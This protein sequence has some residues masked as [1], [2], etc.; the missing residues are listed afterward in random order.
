MAS[1]GRWTSWRPLLADAPA[2]EGTAGGEGGHP[3]ARRAHAAMLLYSAMIAT[4]FPVGAAI[5]GDLDP[6]VLTLLRFIIAALALGLFLR[7]RGELAL[8]RGGAL[9]RYA[10]I[11]LTITIFFVTMFEALRW[12]SPLSTGAM[13]TFVPL[14]T[15][16][17]GFALNRQRSTAAQIG[18]LLLGGLGALWVLFDADLDRLL[19]LD[20]GRGE[21]IFSIGCLAFAAYAP[22]IAR[23]HRG[24]SASLITFWV[25][26]CGGL[27]LFLYCLPRLGGIDWTALPGRLWL[28]VAY[29]AIFNTCITFMLAKFSSVRLPSHKMMAYTYLTPAFVALLEGLLGHGWPVLAVIVGIIVTASATLALQRV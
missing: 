7:L 25:I 13:F 29:L 21:A 17:I 26:V 10:T 2:S 15:A 18:C 24:E 12:T 11:S 23:L 20:I 4:S 22:A 14:M 28:G 6:T 3:Q 16:G 19:A 27:L 8:P 1:A 5:T 9:L